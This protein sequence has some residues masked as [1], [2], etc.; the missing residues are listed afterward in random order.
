MMT[1]GVRQLLKVFVF[2]VILPGILFS[3]CEKFC[4]PDTNQVAEESSPTD[5]IAQQDSN[6][7][8]LMK[9]GT[10]KCMDI[11]D[12]LVAVLLREM[13]ASF[14]YEALKSQAVVARTYGLRRLVESNRHENADICVDSTCCQAYCD[15]DEYLASGGTSE[16]VEK[17]QRAVSETNGEV[18]TYNGALIEATYF[19]CS[20][21]KT[22]DAV[23]V[24]GSE[25]PYL[26]SVDSPG[27]EEAKHYVETVTFSTEEFLRKLDIQSDTEDVTIEDIQYTSGDGVYEV[28]VCGV[29]M[30]GTTIRKRLGLNSTAMLMRVVGDIVMITT[31][32]KGHRVGMSQ[33]GADAMAKCG[34]DYKEILSHYYGDTE[35]VIY[36]LD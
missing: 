18:L 19:A 14:E 34:A 10:V 27:E 21:G 2:G 5:K 3:V 33:Y 13:P 9:D 4:W 8:V 26:R 6:I 31:K 23:A 12:Y 7:S 17:I 32:G 11:N 16:N 35:L 36:M 20:G 15:I 24:W 22:E 28:K 1:P 29:V 30:K 25:V